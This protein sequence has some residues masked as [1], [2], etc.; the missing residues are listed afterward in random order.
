VLAWE[1]VD[2][3]PDCPH[4]DSMGMKQKLMEA[5]YALEPYLRRHYPRF[6]DVFRLSVEEQ[7]DQEKH[8]GHH[9]MGYSA[10]YMSVFSGVVLGMLIMLGV[11]ARAVELSSANAKFVG[12]KTEARSTYKDTKEQSIRLGEDALRASGQDEWIAYLR[13]FNRKHDLTDALLLALRIAGVSKTQREKD[14]IDALERKRVKDAAREMKK[15]MAADAKALKAAHKRA[16]QAG[17]V[18]KYTRRK[19]APEPD[20]TPLPPVPKG[21]LSAARTDEIH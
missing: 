10:K 9:W 12:R 2:L 17:G 4:D 8:N 13:Q 7:N 18:R 5:I 1:I 21:I 19:K 3:I 11:P 14:R 16:A 20:D 15:K 6:G